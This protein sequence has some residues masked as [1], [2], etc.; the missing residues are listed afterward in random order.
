MFYADTVGLLTSCRDPALRARTT[1]ASW[2]PSPLLEQL[3][4]CRLREWVHAVMTDAVIVSTARTASRE[5]LEGRAEHDLRRHA[6]RP[7]RA[8]C[9]RARSHR[10]GEVEDVM[11]GCAA[12]EGTTGGN[13]ARQ[14][15]LRAGFRSPCRGDRESF[16]LLRPADDRHGRAAH[17]HGEGA[18]YRRR[19]PRVHLL[20]AE[21]NE[22]PHAEDPWLASTS[23]RS[24]GACCRRPSRSPSATSS[25]RAPG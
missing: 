12:P 7:C 17:H 1:A 24:T 22:P 9:G 15:A 18:V 21:R 14:M 11:L 4:A 13:I 5:V 8:A 23:P 2:Q 6:R 19:W 10:P 16:L 3:A 25:P 20:R